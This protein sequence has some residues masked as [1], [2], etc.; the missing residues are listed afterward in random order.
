MADASRVCI[1]AFEHKDQ[2]WMVVEEFDNPTDRTP[3]RDLVADKEGRIRQSG[4]GRQG[5]ME[6]DRHPT[7]V[8]AERFA[9]FLAGRLQQGFDE[10]PYARLVLVTSPRFL[11]L[12]RK[13]LSDPVARLVSATVA[14][15]LTRADARE[16]RAHLESKL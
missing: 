12:L 10:H 4:H 7:D 8:E 11:G 16:I 3:V 1:L 6:P 2:P 13:S 9:R 14:K 5:S 15:S